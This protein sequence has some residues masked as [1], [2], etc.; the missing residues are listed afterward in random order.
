VSQLS[1]QTTVLSLTGQVIADRTQVAYRRANLFEKA[2]SSD[3]SISR[4]LSGGADS[5]PRSNFN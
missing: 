5:R 4:F 1:S 2:S 3:G